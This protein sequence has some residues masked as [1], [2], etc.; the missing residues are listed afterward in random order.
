VKINDLLADILGS[1][2]MAKKLRGE[3][4]AQKTSKKQGDFDTL[5]QKETGVKAKGEAT[6]NSPGAKV[7][8]SG[9]AK[10]R[11]GIGSRAEPPAGNMMGEKELDALA[12]RLAAKAGWLPEKGI[13]AGGAMGETEKLP[14]LT[15]KEKAKGLLRLWMD[16]RQGPSPDGLAK[17]EDGPKTSKGDGSSEDTQKDL[18]V[19][20][21]GYPE[22]AAALSAVTE[23]AGILKN[24]KAPNQGTESV[25]PE[26][27][28]TRET[29]HTAGQNRILR[30]TDGWLLRERSS[31]PYIKGALSEEESAGRT[32]AAFARAE[33]LRRFEALVR[34]HGI[35]KPDSSQGPVSTEG[36]NVDGSLVQKGDRS[37]FAAFRPFVSGNAGAKEEGGPIE[38][39]DQG[40]VNGFP[41]SGTMPETAVGI[42]GKTKETSDKPFNMKDLTV[43]EASHTPRGETTSGPVLEVNPADAARGSAIERTVALSEG[44]AQVIEVIRNRNGHKGRMVLEPPELGTVRIEILSSRDQVRLHLFV[45]NAQARDL[46]DQSLDVL[47]QSLSRQGLT[48]AETMVDIDAGGNGGHAAWGSDAASD[49]SS[50]PVLSDGAEE[51]QE[52]GEVIA[53][54]DIDKGLLNWIA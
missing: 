23:E 39:Q 12:E 40:G 34:E 24:P 10:E 41:G 25:L 50:G 46:V 15:Q 13:F 11:A 16:L 19:L 2:R 9:E 35:G 21:G 3:P 31:E 7:A 30:A 47:R 14:E 38:K 5:L 43:E 29:G 48:L 42:S 45:E 18:S 27:T 37:D 36:P 8:F 26:S 33:I 49:A 1:D 44:M 52:P 4:A 28:Q 22:A 53:R 32:N 20:S 54:L 17:A 51:P 6:G